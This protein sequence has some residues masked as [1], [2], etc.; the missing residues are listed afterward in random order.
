MASAEDWSATKKLFYGGVKLQT[1]YTGGHSLVNWPTTCRPKEKGGLGFWTLNGL[2]VRYDCGGYGSSGSTKK[3]EHGTDW[4]CRAIGVTVIF[5]PLPQW[6]W[7]EM[8]RL[9]FSRHH[10]GLRGARQRVWHR[11]CSKRQR[12]KRLR[13]K[14]QCKITERF[15]L[16][17]NFSR[18]LALPDQLFL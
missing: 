6:W 4:T 9:H 17:V 16:K 10:H 3:N 12:E 8:E 5:L 13:S 15:L 14:H 11:R 7:L 18:Y 1:K 2:L